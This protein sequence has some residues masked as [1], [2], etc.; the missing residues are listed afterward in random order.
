MNRA[1]I[2]DLATARFIDRREDVLLLGMPGTGKSHLA[3]A[4]GI[5]AVK[6]GRSVSLR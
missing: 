2:D 3:V 4:L 6:A 1:L 5:E